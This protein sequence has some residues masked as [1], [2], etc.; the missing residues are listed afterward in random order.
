MAFNTRQCR[1]PDS[2]RLNFWP[3]CSRGAILI[4]SRTKTLTAKFGYGVL[5]PLQ[6][7]ATIGLLLKLTG[8]ARANALEATYLLGD[9][10]HGHQE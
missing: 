1:Q 5:P 4:T 2:T 9:G 10:H 7:E 3:Q 6:E 8:M